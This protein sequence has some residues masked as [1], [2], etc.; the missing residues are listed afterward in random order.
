MRD[1]PAPTPT[2]APPELVGKTVAEVVVRVPKTLPPD[3][4][5]AVARAA[6]ADDHV[7]MLLLTDQGRLLGTLVR[8]DLPD[9]LSGAGR[10][11]AHSVLSGRTVSADAPAEEARRLLFERGQRRFAVVDGEGSLL[12]LLC[13][14]RRLTG[15]CSDR[16]VAARAADPG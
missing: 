10:A 14:K 2:P 1:D 16:D 8:D 12:G 5:V 11:L 15:F 13:L 3:T 9:H 4:S 7:H 6:L